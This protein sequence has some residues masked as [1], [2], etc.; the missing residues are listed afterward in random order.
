MDDLGWIREGLK[1]PGKTQSGLA[2]A[3]GRYPSAVTSLL[4]GE[5]D[6]KA[7]EIAIVAEY[8]ET[9]PPTDAS[10]VAV[11]IMGYVGA[12]ASV[13]P[14][15]EQVPPE[16]L[17]T[18]DLPF[19]VPDGLIGLQ[20]RGDS[21]LPRYDDGDVILVWQE[22]PQATESYVGEEVAV[23]THDGF[24]YLKRLLR[25]TARGIYTLESWNARVIEGVRIAW[26]GEIYLTVRLGQMQRIRD[27]ERARSRRSAKA[28][29][30]E[31]AG[32]G[33]LPLG[34]DGEAA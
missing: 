5:R 25:G 2:K 21:M 30:Q 32:M 29:E 14:D 12:G 1:K 16:G 18:V 7:R 8:L 24:R 28:R 9:E 20:V 33:E 17:D 22:Q 27:R 19:P 15:F 23:R 10:P 3:L 4:K 13:E 34:R 11:P 31:T 6:L 26:V